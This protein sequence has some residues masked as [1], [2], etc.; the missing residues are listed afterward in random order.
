MIK[1][2]IRV[3]GISCGAPNRRRKCLLEVVGV[4]Y[5]GN[6]WLEGAMRTTIQPDVADPTKGIAK[7]VTTSPH[8]PQ[9]RLIAL[10]EMVT[11]S[12]TY[13]DIEGLSRKTRLP[14][15][16]TVP[17]KISTE[18][19][20]KPRAR[21]SRSTVRRLATLSC[22]EWRMGRRRFLV[23][24]AGL[25]GMNLDEVLQVC[26]SRE[27]LPEAARVARIVAFSLEKFLATRAH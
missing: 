3:L 21:I 11:K 5:R 8:F 1:K 27:G 2:E 6:R 26:A 17:R 19:A 10:D 25:G 23:Y 4:V 24:H 20:A 14:V 7:M 22:K 13:I 18:R 12:G 16:V 9:L 15:I